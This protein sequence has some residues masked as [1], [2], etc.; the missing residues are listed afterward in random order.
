MFKTPQEIRKRI[1]SCKT[2][3]ILYNKLNPILTDIRPTFLNHNSPANVVYHFPLVKSKHDYDLYFYFENNYRFYNEGPSGYKIRKQ[4]HFLVD[5][6]DEN[7]L[8]TLVAKKIDSFSFHTSLS[9]PFLL[10][11][12]EKSILELKKDFQK[13]FHILKPFPHMYKKLTISCV[14]ECPFNGL[15][16]PVYVV[17]EILDYHRYDFTEICLCDTTGSLSW[18]HFEYIVQYCIFF[19]IHPSKLSFQFQIS[20]ETREIVQKMI[21]YAL[22]MGIHKFD[23]SDS[24]PD[25]EKQTLSYYFF[26]QLLEKIISDQIPKQLD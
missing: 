7:H 10:K 3:F 16:D 6:Q 1:Y 25:T 2:S 18:D 4:R 14:N 21:T 5:V 12:R 11:T 24:F 20:P 9:N 8:K 15:L 17:R 22:K 23:V 19:G 26:Y 13:M